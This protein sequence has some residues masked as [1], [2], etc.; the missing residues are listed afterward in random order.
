MTERAFI[1]LGSNI[2]DRMGQLHKALTLLDEYP[3]VTVTRLSSIYETDPVG[4]TDQTNFLNM[5]AE[6]STDLSPH[7][8]LETALAVEKRLG[9][10]RSVRWGPRTIDLDIL[11]YDQVNIETDVLHIPHPRMRE[12]AFVLIPLAE[13]NPAFHIPGSQLPLTDYI[14]QIPDREGVRLWKQNNGGG[15]FALF[16]S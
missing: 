6:V 10:K 13:M 12:R 14:Q 1:G 9:R 11:V 2:G 4:Y 7:E 15:K 5:V 16:E 3:K 8:L